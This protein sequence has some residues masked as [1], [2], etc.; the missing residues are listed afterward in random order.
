[1]AERSRKESEHVISM[2]TTHANL[3]ILFTAPPS[4]CTRVLITEAQHRVHHTP[5]DLCYSFSLSRTR[6]HTPTH[7]H[8]HTHSHTH[9]HNVALRA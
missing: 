5:R 1:M 9:T 7:T 3:E 4:L 6:T 2:V 8:T